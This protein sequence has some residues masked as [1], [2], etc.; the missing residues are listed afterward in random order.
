MWL[1]PTAAHITSDAI[2]AEEETV[3]AW[4]IEAQANDP[5]PSTTVDREGLDVLQADAAAAV[6]GTDRLVIVVGPAGAGKT[7]MLQ[8]AVDDLDRTGT[9]RRSVW[10]R[11]RRRPTCLGRETG[12]A[13]DTVAKLLH[14]W[15]HPD[16]PPLDRYRLPPGTT[17]IVDEAGTIG[18][19][20]VHQLVRLAHAERWRV[21]LVGDPRQLQAVG[22]GGLFNELCATGRV[23]ELARIHRFTH[24]WEAAASLQLRAGDPVAIDAY[25]AH[26]RIVAG[27]LADQLER[28]ARDWLGHHTDAR[29]VALVASTNDHVDALND[30]VQRVRLTVGDLDPS[31]AVPIGDGEHAHIGDIVA[32]R[33]N[34]RGLCTERGEPVRNRDLWTVVATHGD[35]ALTVSHLGGHG[36]VTLPADYTREHVRLGYAATEHGHQGD[37]VDIS[38]ALVSRATTHRGLYVGVTRGRD[39]N[40]IHVITDTTDLGEAR[41]ILDAVLAHDRADIPAV[42]QRR[43]LAQTNRPE[44]VRE[45]EQVVPAWL[46][47]YRDQL[48]QRRHDLTAGLTERAHRRTEAA[49]ELADL[50]PALDAARAAWQPYADRINEIEHELATVLR[51]AMWQANHDAY[52]AGFGQRHGAARRAKIATWHVDDAQDRIAAIRADGAHDQRT[53]RRRRSRREKARPARQPEHRSLRHRPARPRSA[54]RPRPD[55]RGDRHLD[56][57]G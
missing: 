1:E 5:H 25:E 7:T 38:I 47:D 10:P 12:I 31:T 42:T 49:A 28:I 14:E 18:T 23:H 44:P 52:R 32:S 39:E 46:T 21:V 55:G 30:A 19:S 29:T 50:Q 6:A 34:H 16:R 26:G 53:A 37:T 54:P 36:S 41:D 4:A 57:L 9:A 56:H 2:L 45:P 27:P 48:E 33:R 15:H 22:R 20:T 51:P 40:R 3:L 11:R 43:H 13:S 17:V 24:P 35:G 8:H